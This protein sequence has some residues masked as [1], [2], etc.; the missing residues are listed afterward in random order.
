MVTI[1]SHA[2]AAVNMNCNAAISSLHEHMSLMM[3]FRNIVPL[4]GPEIIT[5]ID[6]RF[7]D[8]RRSKSEN[9]LLPPIDYCFP[10]FSSSLCS[11]EQLLGA[12]VHQHR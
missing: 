1:H 3:E 5:E 12:S 7:F 6:K 2:A 10:A 4:H 11:R 9:M 8:T